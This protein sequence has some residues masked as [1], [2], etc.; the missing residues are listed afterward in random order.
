MNRLVLAFIK[1]VAPALIVLVFLNGFGV[2]G[3]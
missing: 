3:K 2:F 1:F